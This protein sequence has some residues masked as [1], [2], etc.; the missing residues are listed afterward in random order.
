MLVPTRS[1]LRYAELVARSTPGLAE[2]RATEN[3]SRQRPESSG[4]IMWGDR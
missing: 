1:G 2:T 3:G 4:S